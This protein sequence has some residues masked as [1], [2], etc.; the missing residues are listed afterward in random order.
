MKEVEQKLRE[1]RRVVELWLRLCRC[2]GDEW[3]PQA[4]DYKLERHSQQGGGIECG[5]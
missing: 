4:N 5:D 3:Q 1:L 2:K